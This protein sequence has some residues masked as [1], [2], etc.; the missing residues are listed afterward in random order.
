MMIEVNNLRF[1]YSGKKTETL[2]DLSFSI[3]KGEVFGFLG[4]SGSGKST[5]QKILIGL[6]KRY[7]GTV[8]VGNNN[9][10]RSGPDYYENIGVVFEFP[11]LYT[12][13]TALENLRYF[14]GL[15]KGETAKPEELLKMVGLESDA[16]VKVSSFSK[17]MKMRLN[18]CRGLVNKPS[19]L[20]LD[21]P[22]SGLDP[23]NAREIVSIIK[24]KKREGTT[25]FLTTHNMAVAD[26]LCDR[27]AFIIDGTIVL[28]D[29]PRK[30]KLQYGKKL[31]K[32]EYRDNSG[33]NSKTFPI[34]DLYKN[35]SFLGILKERELE[36]IHSM[37]ATLE[38]VFI[39]VTGRELHETN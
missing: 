2:H 11:N 34:Q 6:L 4:P 15:Y 25:I 18:F 26:E 39:S 19:L 24:Q 29:S 14:S 12:R 13:F 22:T 35:S 27:V 37:E 23:V 1:T 21:E 17:G 7:S 3:K 36:T 16:G 33:V 5:T 9:I 28:T 32:V 38:D 31:V 10:S 30:L 8:L 20:F